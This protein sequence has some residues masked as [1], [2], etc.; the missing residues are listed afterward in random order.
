MATC[1]EGE[2]RDFFHERGHCSH[3]LLV[4]VTALNSLEGFL[5]LGVGAIRIKILC[6][7]STCAEVR[8]MVEQLKKMKSLLRVSNCISNSL[9]KI[10]AINSQCFLADSS[11]STARS[12]GLEYILELQFWI[13]QFYFLLIAQ[14][15]RFWI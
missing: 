9:S 13:E 8:V 14:K 12:L 11:E 2:I 10:S 6:L 3:E 7:V 4:S 1:L 5:G 15:K